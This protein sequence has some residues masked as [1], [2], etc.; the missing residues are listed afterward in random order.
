MIKIISDNYGGDEREWLKGH[1]VELLGKYQGDDIETPIAVY[2]KIID[3]HIHT[4]NGW[5]KCK[6]RQ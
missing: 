4:V 5:T 2:Q 1:C 3:S 6:G